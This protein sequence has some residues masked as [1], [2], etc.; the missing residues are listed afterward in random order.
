MDINQGDIHWV[1][2]DE[3]GGIPHPQ[4]VIQDDAINYSRISSVVVCAL[5]TN[6]TRAKAPGNVLLNEGEANLAKQSVVLVSQV[7]AVDKSKLNDYIGTLDGQRVS[8]I[9]AGMQFQ[10]RMGR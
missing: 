2:L 8:Q 1:A 7:S 5:S 10:Q 9:L 4:V 3:F 6:L